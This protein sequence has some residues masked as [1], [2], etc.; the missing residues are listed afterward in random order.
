MILFNN[1]KDKIMRLF[2]YYSISSNLSQNDITKINHRVA[3][4]RKSVYFFFKKLPFNLKHKRKIIGLCITFL[5]GINQPLISSRAPLAINRL[6]N[7]KKISTISKLTNAQIQQ[8]NNLILEF[9]DD[10]IKMEEA[11]FQ[12]RG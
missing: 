2:L 3:K 9:G 8:L 12:V 1:R 11:I 6:S 10:S 5:F 7:I 4:N